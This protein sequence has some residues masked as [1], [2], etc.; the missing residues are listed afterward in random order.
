MATFGGNGRPRAGSRRWS[1]LWA[2]AP[3]AAVMSL[4]AGTSVAAPVT[5]IDTTHLRAEVRAGTLL[6]SHGVTVMCGSEKG[7]CHAP[8]VTT[9]P[10][11]T[12]VLSTDTPVGL[13][14]G[15][16]ERAY[17][18]PP[19]SVG[20]RGTVALIT[21]GAYPALEHD[22]GVYRQEYGLP[23]CTTANGCLKVTD[24]DGGP[25]VPASTDGIDPEVEEDWAGE[26]SL[27]VDMA[28]AACP[29]CRILVLETSDYLASGD[30][31]PDEKGAAYA[32]AYATAV[33][34]GADAVS[35]SDYIPDSPELDGPVGKK[36]DHPG[37][38]LM[39]SAGDVGSS[40]A[41]PSAGGPL[42]TKQASPSDATEDIGWPQDLPWVVSV[43]GTLLKPS[44][45][46]RTTFTE[47]AWAGLPG[48]CATALAATAGQ[49]AS[50]AANCGG[51]R[52][53]TDIAAIADPSSGPAAYDSYAPST[54][55]PMNWVVS[56]GTSASSPFVAGWY[57]RSSGHRTDSHGPSALYAAPRSTFHDI[58]TGDGPHSACTS[59]GW[60]AVVCQAGPGWDGPTGLGTPDGLGRF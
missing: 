44:D 12:T 11:S 8:V 34:L 58:T 4:A 49:P 19:A 55:R 46:G 26:S 52:A 9:A 36:L 13:G 59:L 10:D 20:H 38:P 47:Q 17:H 6:A 35:L 32:T 37:V 15:D 1:A 57:A 14:A 25:P 41:T 28:S 48:S 16:L 45:A 5:P 51:H 42:A 22:L 31:S 40:D 33:R 29:D 24:V 56:G 23:A 18:L 2:A 21:G 60:P 27:D 39:A 3:L 7:G 54:G 43:G 50:I 30:P 53:G